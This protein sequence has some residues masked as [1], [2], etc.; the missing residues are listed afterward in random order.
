[1]EKELEETSMRN[2]VMRAAI[3]D[4]LGKLPGIAFS[5]EQD[6]GPRKRFL[7]EEIM[8]LGKVLRGALS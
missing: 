8:E 1:M 7:E 6:L 5:V 4:V 3:Y 2:Q